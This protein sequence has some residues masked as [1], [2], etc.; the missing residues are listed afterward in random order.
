MEKF[1]YVNCEEQIL[2]MTLPQK[3]GHRIKTPS[4]ELTIL[5]SSCW[6][7][8]F[9]RNNALNFFI[10][11]LVF[12]KLLIVS[13]CILS[14][15]PCI[16]IMVIIVIWPLF[17]K[18]PVNQKPLNRIGIFWYHFTPRKSHLINL[19][20]SVKLVKVGPHGLSVFWGHPIYI[21]IYIWGMCLYIATCMKL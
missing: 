4:S 8:I 10:L 21:Y 16:W 5:V 15:P 19:M 3:N 12:L 9:I 6:E 17:R 7:K 11:S 18:M 14:G 1:R 20:I 2:K 13:C